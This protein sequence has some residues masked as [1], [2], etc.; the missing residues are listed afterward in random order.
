[1]PKQ[2]ISI[3]LVRS[4]VKPL[5]SMSQ[6]SVDALL[7]TLERYYTD[8]RVT[9]VNTAADL[10]GIAERKPD[11]V[12]LTVKC[13]PTEARLGREDPNMVW[14]SDFLEEHG[15]P[16]T[17]S[18]SVAHQ[19]ELSK[20]LAKQRAL[21]AGLDTSPFCVIRKAFSFMPEGSLLEYPLFIKPSDRGGGL[22][23]DAQ[24]I[25]HNQ[26][27]A[28]SKFASI[29]AD[30]D[31]DSLVE[32]YLTGREFSVAI[33]K[34]EED[35]G[36]F[37]MPLELAI[38]SDFEGTIMSAEMKSQNVEIVTAV[39]DPVIRQKIC[40]L[41]TKVFQA[42]NAR[43]YGRIDIRMDESG[44]PQFL[45][46]N[47]IPSLIENYGSFPKASLMNEGIAYDEMIL[48]IVRLALAR[49]ATA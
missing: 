23:V 14:V 35:D 33:L 4:T 31:S 18:G 42:L 43:D 29:S 5:S 48:R 28:E 24:S 40:T 19:L 12:F 16:H 7:P 20:P 10:E 37:A 3:E 27:E 44:V 47:L 45:E 36:Y 6:R 11:L 15:I 22:G 30:Y 32:E 38:S 17:G 39:T 21:E 41:A 2:K 26:D 49:G 25:A 13:L 46:A 9:T 8:V 1:M 34:R